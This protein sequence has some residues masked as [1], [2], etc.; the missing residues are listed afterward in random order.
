[1]DGRDGR[2]AVEFVLASYQSARQGTKVKL[3]LG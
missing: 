3:P 1:V 2:R